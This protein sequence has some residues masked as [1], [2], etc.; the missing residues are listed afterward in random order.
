MLQGENLLP[1]ELLQDQLVKM[2]SEGSILTCA[3]PITLVNSDCICQGAVNGDKPF[4][5]QIMLMLTDQ[6]AHE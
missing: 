5:K 1:L 2:P 3:T 6:Q 4:F